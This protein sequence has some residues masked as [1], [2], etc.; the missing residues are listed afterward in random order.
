MNKI[1]LISLSLLLGMVAAGC[2]DTLSEN[3]NPDVAHTN[4]AK[5]A[6]P[7]VVFYS[8][9]IVYDHAQYN[10]FLSQALTTMGKSQT[11]SLPYQSGWQFLTV[12]RHPQW[13]RH[14]YDI[15][16]NI[17]VMVEEAQKAGFENYILI[18]RAIKLMSTQLTTDAF[19]D[20]PRVEAYLSNAPKYD[21]Q[22]SVYKWM[23]E[24]A[25][26]LVADMD[27]YIRNENGIADDDEPI[28]FE[29]DRIYGGDINGWKGLVYAIKARLLLRNIPNI[30][31]SPARC[32]EIFDVAQKAIDT[33]RT[34]LKNG[35][36][37]YGAWFGNEPRY[38]FDGGDNTQNAVWGPANPIINAWESRENGLKNAVP[39]K[40]MMQDLMGIC[41]P[42]AEND[43]KQGFWGSE[44]DR[45]QKIAGTGYG[46]DPRLM[47]LFRPQSGPFSASNTGTSRVLMRYLRNNIGVPATDYK[48]GHYPELYCGAYA[49]GNDAYNPLFTMEELFFIQAEALYWMGD[50]PAAC[51]KATEATRQNIER[52][53]E[54]F[55]ADNN[56]CYPG[57]ECKASESSAEADK[58]R[59]EKLV[60]A[61]FEPNKT[62]EFAGEKIAPS[63][64]TERGNKHWFFNRSEYTLS[65]LMQQKYLSLYLQPEQ[66]TDMR[67]YHYSSDLNEIKISGEKVQNTNVMS[68]TIYP[69]LQRPFNLYAAYWVDGLTSTKEKESTWITRYN[70]DPEC[71]EKYNR[72]ELERLGAYKNHLWLREPMI[73]SKQPGQQTSLTE[74]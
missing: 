32:Q 50:R 11:G 52:H 44:D 51:D 20:I 33:W 14:Y 40:F 25:D 15:G 6:L 39:S 17:N 2:E 62:T 63:P 72:P 10:V 48:Q 35:A 27:A 36:L 16:Q 18:A 24:E 74:E 45:K 7:V 68:E 30:D 59:F 47:L 56:G 9:Q 12:N 21:T 43:G 67:R 31:A 69:T 1:K 3:V 55:L 4:E 65:D 70:Y 61:F 13:R 29:T 54:R 26:D 28:S 23:L 5:H 46:N 8:Q 66:W 41:S 37:L 49:G 42:G 19:G 58:E 53:L 34:P 38:K 71:E 22:A 73:W 60:I 57:A 64:C